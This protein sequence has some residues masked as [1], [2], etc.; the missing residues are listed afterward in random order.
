[1]NQHTALFSAGFETVDIL[2]H[3]VRTVALHLVCDVSV[4]VQ[5]ERRR[6]MAKVALHRL[7]I[8]PCPERSHGVAVPL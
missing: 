2:L 1:M 5:R 8:I 7:D 4:N 3:P 6:S